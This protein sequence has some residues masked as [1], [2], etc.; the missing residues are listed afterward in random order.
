M[1]DVIGGG[2]IFNPPEAAI[3]FT[4][5]IVDKTVLMDGEIAITARMNLTLSVDHHVLDGVTG[6]CFL[7]SVKEL[8]ENPT[9]ML[10]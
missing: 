4:S 7:Q 2:A 5:S 9:L 1:F 6:T 8:I 3:L 10:L